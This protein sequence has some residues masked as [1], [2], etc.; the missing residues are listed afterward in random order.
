M[1]L[2]KAVKRL[3]QIDMNR[4]RMKGLDPIGYGQGLGNT[5][6]A[7][8]L[9]VDATVISNLWWITV[10]YLAPG[11]MQ[12]YLLSHAQASCTY[13]NVIQNEASFTYHKYPAPTDFQ[14]TKASIKP[15]STAAVYLAS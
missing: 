11:S 7:Q 13:T 9:M 14:W 3:N 2:C 12:F 10:K 5:V 15:G 6:S 1:R 8:V 4:V